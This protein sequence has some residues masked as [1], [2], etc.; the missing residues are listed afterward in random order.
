MS[1]INN[2]VNQ[3]QKTNIKLLNDQILTDDD[4]MKDLVSQFEI[5][6]STHKQTMAIMDA[7]IK[8]TTDSIFQMQT[9]IKNVQ[10]LIS[11]NSTEPKTQNERPN[12]IRIKQNVKIVIE[13]QEEVQQILSEHRG[14]DPLLTKNTSMLNALLQAIYNTEAGQNAI[15]RGPN[16]KEVIE[17]IEKAGE[18]EPIDKDDQ[19]IVSALQ[20]IFLRMIYS[21]KQSISTLKFCKALGIDIGKQEDANELMKNVIDKLE[22]A[23]KAHDTK[24]IFEHTLQVYQETFEGQTGSTVRCLQCQNESQTQKPLTD[25]MMSVEEDF[26]KCFA[27]MV[28][29]HEDLECKKCKGRQVQYFNVQSV[30]DLLCMTLQRLQRNEQDKEVKF[31]IFL[32]LEFIKH[33]NALELG[34]GKSVA[35]MAELFK[36]VMMPWLFF[37]VEPRNI[38]VKDKAARSLLDNKLFMEHLQIHYQYVKCEDLFQ[39]SEDELLKI[40]E[41]NNTPNNLYMLR[42]IVRQRNDS[43][44]TIALER[45]NMVDRFQILKFDNQFVTKIDKKAE[46]I[47]AGENCK[48]FYEKVRSYEHGS[49]YNLSNF[50]Q[51]R[52]IEENRQ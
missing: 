46:E 26:F 30:P 7:Y 51:D 38:T 2:I 13:Q 44:C 1:N 23:S 41:F 11:Q 22:R 37:K 15:L 6:E 49:C 47:S 40:L 12:T 36:M 24:N 8:D 4:Y 27:A 9:E 45:P 25:L 19:S 32:D 10:K 48:F 33:C 52:I 16:D 18:L 50:V 14:L 42:T 3:L 21:Q 28:E 35:E 29:Q 31:P 20:L 34:N 5:Q 39:D 17:R 43:F